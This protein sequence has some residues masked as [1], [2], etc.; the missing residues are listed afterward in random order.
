MIVYNM[1]VV[2][3]CSWN[4]A[5]EK[6]WEVERTEDG[7]MGYRREGSMFIFVVGGWNRTKKKRKK[8]GGGG[9]FGARA[10]LMWSEAG[11]KD[12]HVKLIVTRELSRSLHCMTRFHQIK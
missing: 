11:N 7:K 9:L 3:H 5:K 6:I 10:T 2:Q 8:R 4:G 1:F 12:Q